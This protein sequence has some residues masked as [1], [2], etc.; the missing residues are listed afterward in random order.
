M[1]VS[2]QKQSLIV[3]SFVQKLRV[4]AYCEHRWLQKLCWSSNLPFTVKFVKPKPLMYDSDLN[5]ATADALTMLLH[6]QHAL[7]RR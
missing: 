4:A 6:N 2:G 3:S 7:V 1:T 5:I